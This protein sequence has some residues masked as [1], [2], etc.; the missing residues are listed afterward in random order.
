MPYNLYTF[1][2][3]HPFSWQ[4][5]WEPRMRRLLF[6]Y[7]QNLKTSWSTFLVLLTPLHPKGIISFW[8]EGRFHPLMGWNV[9]RS[10]GNQIYQQDTTVQKIHY[11]IYFLS[12]LIK[13]MQYSVMIQLRHQHRRLLPRSHDV[14]NSDI[15]PNFP[16]HTTT[17]QLTRTTTELFGY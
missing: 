14:W 17:V 3:H 5:G 12:V 9:H 16:N 2:A 8:V 10:G 6:Q 11:Y 4:K 1:E 15:R 7:G 13:I